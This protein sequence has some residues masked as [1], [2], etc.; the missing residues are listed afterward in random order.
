M[1]IVRRVALALLALSLLALCYGGMQLLRRP[2]LEAYDA[3]VLPEAPA[4]A[5]LRVRYAG[6]A[7]LLFDDGE[8]AWMTDGFFSRPGLAR[9]V[10]GKIAPDEREIDRGLERLHVSRLAAVVPVHSH[11][12]HAMD[13]PLVA[14]KTGALLVGS[15]S[16][17]N[18]GRGAGLPEERM[19]EVLPGD[20]LE[21]GKFTLTFLASRHT[22]TLLTSGKITET[23]DAPLVPPA[24]ASAWHEGATWSILVEHRSGRRLLVQGSAGFIPG[25]LADQRA[26]TVFLGVGTLGNKSEDYRTMYWNEVVRAVGARRVIPIHWDDFWHP[27]GQQPQPLP[28][29]LDDFGQTMTDLTERGARARVEVRLAPLFAAFEP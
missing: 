8:T 12:D 14:R 19:R 23:I 26:D 3:L 21:L 13:A 27:L 4:S 10:S 24:R 7:T 16:T 29:L 5:P 6:V 1:R 18:I 25:A 15:T 2:S 20:T 22:P 17:L 28:L 11:Y 9:T